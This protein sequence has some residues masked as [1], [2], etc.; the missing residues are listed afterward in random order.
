MRNLRRL[1]LPAIMTREEMFATMSRSPEVFIWPGLD[2]V[3]RDFSLPPESEL[4]VRAFVVIL[5][6]RQRRRLL[7]RARSLVGRIVALA[8]VAEATEDDI[9]SASHLDDQELL[10]WITDRTVS[11]ERLTEGVE[12]ARTVRVTL[13]LV[14][15]VKTA[16]ESLDDGVRDVS[17][18]TKLMMSRQTDVTH[19]TVSEAATFMSVTTKTI[20]NRIAAGQLT[21][22]AIPGT[23]KSGIPVRELSSGWLPIRDTRM[24]AGRGRR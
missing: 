13:E 9:A 1:K 5:C 20:R 12:I 24:I 8:A 17:N 10:R 19:V 18:L 15:A 6:R 11:N 22:E 21:L 23:R 4:K 2:D 3:L 14:A 16:V 7:E